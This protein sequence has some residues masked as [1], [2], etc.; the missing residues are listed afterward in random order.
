V[1]RNPKVPDYS[2]LDIFMNTNTDESGA[3][4]TAAFSQWVA[5]RQRDQAQ[6]AKQGRLL[7]EEKEA[8][9]KRA[10]GQKGSQSADQ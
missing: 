9:A 6:I 5:D 8:A 10:G 4:T 7:R 2:G 3:A 1:K